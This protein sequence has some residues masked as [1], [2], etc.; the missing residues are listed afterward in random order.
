MNIFYDK[1]NDLLY[2]RFD[3]RQQT[4]TNLIVSDNIIFDIGIDGKLV[5]IEIL[6]ASEIISISQLSYV[7]FLIQHNKAA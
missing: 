6:N 1:N 5:A 2:I 7:D 3:E 4:V